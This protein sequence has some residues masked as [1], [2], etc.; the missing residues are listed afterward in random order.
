MK[1]KFCYK[2]TSDIIQLPHL[3][4]AALMLFLITLNK[5]A[6][7]LTWNIDLYDI[8]SSPNLT[9]VSVFVYPLELMKK[10]TRQANRYVSG[11]LNKVFST[12]TLDSSSVKNLFGYS[13]YIL[14]L[15]EYTLLFLSFFFFKYTY[16]FKN[17]NPWTAT[18]MLP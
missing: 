8:R 18:K 9:P 12:Y 7:L 17:S 11:K 15:V 13:S 2:T 6:V 3:E 5:S 10:S 4:E 14:E 1:N 16:C